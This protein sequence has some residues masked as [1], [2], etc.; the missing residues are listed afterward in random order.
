MIVRKTRPEEA[1]RINEIFAICFEMPYANCPCD[2]ENDRDTHWAAFGDD[3]EM[4]SCITV[5]EFSIR[6]DGGIS[7]MAGIG[8]VETL[9]QYRRQGGIRA[10]F[11]A[12]LPDLYQNGFDISYLYPFSTAYYRKFGYE[13]CV[14]KYCWTVNLQLLSAPKLEGHFFLAE[15]SRPQTVAIQKIDLTWEQQFNMMV[16]H[17]DEDYKWATECDPAAKQ[18]FTYVWFDAEN[19][20]KAYTTFRIAAENGERNIHCSRFCFSDKA[21]FL[22]LMQV[23][24][25]MAADHAKAKF[26]TP[27]LP[28]LQ[29]LMPEWSLGAVSWDLVA[30]A[31]MV[32]VVN[33][34]N[35]LEKARYLGSGQVTLEIQDPQIP[36]N[37]GRFTIQFENG[38]ALRVARTEMAADAI[39][40]ISTFSALIAG[41]CDWQE[42]RYTFSGLEVVTATNCLNQVFYRKPMMIVDYF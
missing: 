30:S 19:T 32:R 25:S 34:Q 15:K 39:M 27:V 11:E 42:A 37:S 23:F 26:N 14:Q 24:K 9:P 4:M 1:R 35:V 20:P 29:Y 7:K 17:K 33:V 36:E 6:F 2:P 18:E 13:C 21:G 31:G 10:C 8:A 22:G 5:P 38:R 3:G 12:L 41:V 28:A 40:T 16:Q